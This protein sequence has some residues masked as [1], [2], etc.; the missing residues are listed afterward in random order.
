M[1]KICIKKCKGNEDGKVFAH[2]NSKGDWSCVDAETP[3]KL[4]CKTKKQIYNSE[5]D[6][7]EECPRNRRFKKTKYEGVCV[8]QSKEYILRQRDFWFS[9]E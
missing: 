7:C 5:K 4:T 3:A 9:L 8:E 2:Q 6:A 1:F